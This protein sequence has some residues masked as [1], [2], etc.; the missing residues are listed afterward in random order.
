MAKL[1]IGTDE[2]GITRY[3]KSYVKDKSEAIKELKRFRSEREKGTLI[4][5]NNLTVGHWLDY[6]LNDIAK[7]TVSL[8]TYNL[9][10]YIINKTIKPTLGSKKLSK[11][12]TSTIQ[13]FYSK[14]LEDGRS[15]SYV[16]NIH[17][18]L[19]QTL[20][21]AVR[22]KKIGFNVVANCKKPRKQRKDILVLDREKRLRFLQEAFSTSPRYFP[23]F[24]TII[25]TG[26]RRGEVLAL[27]WD[28]VDLNKKLL[29]VTETIN[30]QRVKN[31]TTEL[32]F[33]DPKTFKSKRT[34][35]LSDPVVQILKRHKEKQQEDKE[36]VDDL[37][38]DNNLVFATA[39]GAP[40][41]PRNLLRSLQNI[42]EKC[43][44]PKMT[45][46]SLRH[47]F[48]TMLIEKGENPAV[49]QEYLGHTSITT[50]VKTYVH[51]IPS[52][53]EQASGRMSKEFEKEI[54]S[55]NLKE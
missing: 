23:I 30:R 28:K 19:N 7:N 33:N 53:M 44:I 25:Y 35:H 5:P 18:I 40:I 45:V 11:L 37:Y 43:G 49:I 24:M 51:I 50:T 16:N 8:S 34:I 15:T 22:E 55:L 36:L 32:V 9:Y 39:L 13:R 4:M 31:G 38:Q 21:Q 10:R 26:L 52:I 48:A 46:H 42:C 14:Q 20:Q 47:T 1:P 3:A 54:L 29:T 17:C 12:E 2:N 27:K 6:W 41:E